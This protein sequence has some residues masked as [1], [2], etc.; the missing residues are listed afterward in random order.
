MYEKLVSH[1]RSSFGEIWCFAWGSVCLQ[2]RS[3]LHWCNAYHISS[4]SE[5]LRCRDSLIPASPSLISLSSTLVQPSIEWVTVVYSSPTVDRE[6]WLMVLR[7]R[8]CQSF[9]ACH[10]EVC[11][12]LFCSLYIPAK[13]LSWLRSDYMPMQMTPHYR[14]MFARQQTDLL[15]MS[16]STGLEFRNSPITGEWYWIQTKLRL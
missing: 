9:Q 4:P 6:S 10:R 15:M 3:E 8:G 1:N 13:C 5:V 2:E 11:L 16:P 12:V 7:V 14:Q